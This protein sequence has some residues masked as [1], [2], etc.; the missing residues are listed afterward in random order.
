MVESYDH[1]EIL[2]L[3]EGELDPERER[4]LREELSQDPALLE[5]ID[6]IALDREL[7]A[8]RSYCSATVN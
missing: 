1:D 7:L 8:W 2:A 3:I 5:A 4:S 6:Q